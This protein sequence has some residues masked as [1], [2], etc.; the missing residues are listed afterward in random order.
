MNTFKVGDKVKIIG[1][2]NIG[3]VPFD[4]GT[5]VKVDNYPTDGFHFQVRANELTRP[6]KWN[7]DAWV[8]WFN[9]KSLEPTA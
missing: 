9:E 7:L 8:V 5:V 6:S 4:F 3:E 2:C 1:P